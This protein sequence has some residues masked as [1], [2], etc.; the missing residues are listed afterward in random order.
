MAQDDMQGKTVLVTGAGGGIGLAT[1]VGLAK[2]GAHVLLHARHEGRGAPAVE[3]ARR[4]SG[5]QHIELVTG[6][7]SL[8]RDVRGIADQV[9]THGRLDVLINNAATIPESRRLTE[10]GLEMQFA[11]NHLAYYMLANLLLP[12]LRRAPAGRI[13][14]VSSFLH[15]WIR[16]INF[17]N[18]Q[19]EQ[20]YVPMVL[21]PGWGTY[22]Q[23]KLMNV[24]FTTEMA[25]RLKAAGDTVTVN[26]LNPG[27]IASDITRGVPPWFNAIYKRLI[28]GTDKGARTSI[29]LA[30][31][32]H[33]AATSGEYYV[34]SALAS[35]AADAR[36]PAL[37]GRLWDI[38]AQAT[39]VDFPQP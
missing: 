29:Y 20:A 8:Q 28:G 12:L 30:S 18:L 36:N 31:S 37:T 24:M 4:Q 27:L 19:A 2:L 22:A 1:V 33:V 21:G 38:S 25:R 34:N 3:E 15:T 9:A 5:S 35:M 16:G 7:L 6:D 17:D 23:T 13:I 14:N 10:D 26:A 32:P 39:G 11:V